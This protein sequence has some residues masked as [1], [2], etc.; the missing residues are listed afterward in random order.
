MI[1]SGDGNKAFNL[2]GTNN[3]DVWKRGEKW[4]EFTLVYA[5]A[6]R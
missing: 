6:L 1:A 2:H 4:A 3:A 5:S